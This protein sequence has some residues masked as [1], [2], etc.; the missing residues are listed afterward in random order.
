MDRSENMRRIRSKDMRPELAVRSLV[1]KMGYR[2]RLHRKDL[3]GT[4]DMVFASRR[5]VIFIHGCYWHGHNCKKGHIPES[6]LEYWTPKLKRNRARDQ[7]NAKALETAGWQVLVVW[8][9]DTKNEPSLSRR[10]KRFLDGTA[11]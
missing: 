9:C 6:N 5:K 3:P 1:H 8:E 4:P 2:Y 11:R 7:K 10:I